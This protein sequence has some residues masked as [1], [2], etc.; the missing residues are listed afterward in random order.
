MA[1][2]QSQKI[3]PNNLKESTAGGSHNGHLM[4]NGTVEFELE[5]VVGKLGMYFAAKE[6]GM[7]LSIERIDF[8]GVLQYNYLFHPEDAVWKEVPSLD[9]PFELLTTSSPVTK[10]MTDA[11]YELL[12]KTDPESIKKGFNDFF[13]FRF[14]CLKTIMV[15]VI[16]IVGERQIRNIKV[17]W[18]GLLTVLT[19]T[20]R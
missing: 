12:D 6:A 9:G 17:L 8:L 14:I 20:N 18:S 15:P 7:N 5:R 3:D 1:V 13:P 10:V 4:W 2:K 19:G 16:R 11:D